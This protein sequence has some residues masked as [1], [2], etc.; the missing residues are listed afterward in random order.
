MIK[1]SRQ[2]QIRNVIWKY[3]AVLSL[4]LVCNSTIAAGTET[5]QPA[6]LLLKDHPLVDKVYD[7]HGKQLIDKPRLF[8]KLAGAGYVLVGEIHDNISNHRNEA[9]VIDHLAT[10]NRETDVAFE[11]IDDSQEKFIRDR[12]INSAGQLIELLNHVDTG[13]D[14]ETY[15]RLVFESV[16]RAG[17]S[18]S[19]ANIDRGRLMDIVMQHSSDIPDGT[20]RLL[21]ATHFTPEL[22]MEMQKDII[23]SHCNMLD[24]EQALPMVK[25][26]RIRDAT[27]AASLLNSSADLKVLIAG[28]GH[29][30]RDSGVP[31]YILAQDRMA[32]VIS[33]AMIEVDEGQD[34]VSSY[35]RDWGNNSLPF[36]Y[37]WFTARADREDPC[38]EFI[39]QFEKR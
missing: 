11:M 7:V 38:I 15:Y 6:A 28:D 16:I 26:Q 31:R 17:F 29:I 19:P 30:R 35:A 23:E 18:I 3:C 24:Q 33:V 13:W 22:E 10:R 39:K 21:S 20:S 34:E 9:E 12:K 2:V 5:A 32:T 37:V 8:E 27:M 1:Q 14:Y 36:D 4:G 25:A